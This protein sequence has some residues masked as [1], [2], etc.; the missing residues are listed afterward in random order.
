[1]IYI[2]VRLPER[3]K[4]FNDCLGKSMCLTVPMCVIETNGFSAR[5]E[6]RG[7]ER[8]V[9]LFLLQHESI[10]VGDYLLVHLGEAR[11]KIDKAAADA[12]WDLYD[13]M[14]ARAEE[15]E[16]GGAAGS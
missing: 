9:S 13:E 4:Y 15:A 7:V 12:A 8:E 1:L 16:R 14:F 5:C 3:R 2:K 6:A 11:E 10:G